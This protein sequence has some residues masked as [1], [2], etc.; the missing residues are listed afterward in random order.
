MK[1]ILISRTQDQLDELRRAVEAQGHQVLHAVLRNAGAALHA[2]LPADKADILVVDSGDTPQRDLEALAS[3]T[4]AQPALAV[5][6]LSASRDADVLIAAMRAGVRE[7]LP[8][9]IVP[10]DLNAALRRLAQRQP[11]APA[12][13]RGRVTAFISCKGG[14]GAT[15]LAT[16]VA[17][18]LAAEHG[19]TTALVDMD[20]QYGDASCFVTDRPG[21]SNLADL[22]RNV[23]RLDA[24]LLA[25]SMTEISPRFHLLA[26]PEEPES[27]L[28]ITAADVEHVLDAVAQNYQ[29]VV[30]DVERVLDAASIKALDRAETVYVVL[31]NMVPY[32]RDA[33]RL[34]RIMRKL[35]Y[36]D[37]KLRLVV[38][39]FTREGGIALSQ[40]EKALG[41][42]VAHVVPDNFPD[43]AEAVNMGVALPPLRPHSNVTKAMRQIAQELAGK[44]ATGT[45][46]WIGRLVGAHD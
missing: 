30:L 46:S 37:S 24:R 34:L 35:D 9:P 18:L 1:V 36:P 19:K 26:A 20:L 21:K 33:K 10:A 12:A 23:D 45:V 5:A 4:A 7:V 38:S 17:H 2:V 29:Y 11:T 41:L 6:M 39:Q 27:A 8:R 31:K 40:V 3:L 13:P 42:R 22:A 28:S 25:A 32:V 14:S 16:N 44:P 15:F 43:V